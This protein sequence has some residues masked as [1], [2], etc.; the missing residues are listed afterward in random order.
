MAGPQRAVH[1]SPIIPH[2]LFCTHCHGTF[3]NAS[4]GGID[5]PLERPC[6]LDSPTSILCQGCAGK[7]GTCMTAEKT[8]IGDQWDL[9]EIWDWYASLWL[10]GDNGHSF[11]VECLEDISARQIG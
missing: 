5:S 11:D 10:Q 3:T 1:D 4:T 8:M 6:I 7:K 9:A 2:W